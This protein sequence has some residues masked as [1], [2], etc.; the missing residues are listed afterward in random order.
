MSRKKILVADVEPLVDKLNG[1]VA[2][3]ARKLGVTRSTVYARIKESPTLQK[4]L[5]DARQTMLDAAENKLHEAVLGGNL[6]A[7]IFFLKT[8]GKDR[9]YTERSE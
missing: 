4:R 2:A 5:E 6:T 8:Q 3:I 7:I 1:N 9:G